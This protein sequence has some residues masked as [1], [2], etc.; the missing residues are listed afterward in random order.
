MGELLIVTPSM[1][2]FLQRYGWM[3]L[4]GGS[5]LDRTRLLHRTPV[6]AHLEELVAARPFVSWAAS[7]FRSTPTSFSSWHRPSSVPLPVMA[8]FSCP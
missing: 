4:G 3:K 8:M 1:R 6:L 2:M 7:A 5:D